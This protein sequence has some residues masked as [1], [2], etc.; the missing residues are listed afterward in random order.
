MANPTDEIDELIPLG[1]HEGCAGF[2]SALYIHLKRHWDVDPRQNSCVGWFI[3]R[4]RRQ[5]DK[6]RHIVESRVANLKKDWNSYV[7]SLMPSELELTK[8]KKLLHAG[9]SESLLPT[10]R[11][12]VAID[13]IKKRPPM[14]KAGAKKKRPLDSVDIISEQNR[15]HLR[16]RFTSRERDMLIMIRAVGFFLNPVYR[17][18][19][20]PAVVRD[21][22]HEYMPESRGK[23]VQSLMAAGVREM[24]RPAR[25]AYLQ[26]IVRNLSTFQEMRDLRFQL[27]SA[28]LSTA[29]SKT[30]FFKNAFDVANRLLFMVESDTIDYF[31]EHQALPVTA[32]SNKQFE[33]FL[34]ATRVSS[35]EDYVLDI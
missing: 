24:V 31:S 6:I 33:A 12:T 16:S 18:W 3:A 19:L 5:S 8:S 23:T 1:P 4:F 22:M 26:R 34:K 7:K 15:L 21:I 32:T 27:A 10:T 25:L 20:D 28:P 14:K 2:D 13:P 35:S 17:F 29:E 9:T 30:S 11:C